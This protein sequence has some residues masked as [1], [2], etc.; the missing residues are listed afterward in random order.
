MHEIG[1]QFGLADHI[2]GST[3]SSIYNGAMV[4]NLYSLGVKSFRL[5]AAELEH[6]RSSLGTGSLAERAT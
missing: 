2:D 1:H 3:G 4:F 6:I 5:N